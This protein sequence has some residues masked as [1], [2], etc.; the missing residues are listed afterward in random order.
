MTIISKKLNTTRTW[1]VKQ[2]IQCYEDKLKSFPYGF[3]S[4]IV[5]YTKFYVRYSLAALAAE[6]FEC[7]HVMII[8][9]TS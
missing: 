7:E 3:F 5:E 6:S 8:E 9:R 1:L 2:R 4:S